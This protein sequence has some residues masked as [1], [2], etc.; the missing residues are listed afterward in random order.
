MNWTA[1]LYVTVIAILAIAL[2]VN[3]IWPRHANGKWW[4]VEEVD[5]FIEK[6]PKPRTTSGYVMQRI[7]LVFAALASI[8]L[9]LTNDHKSSKS[10]S[11]FDD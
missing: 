7:I 4:S 9:M 11:D 3:W 6:F 8:G 10:S 2:L 5:E 1:L